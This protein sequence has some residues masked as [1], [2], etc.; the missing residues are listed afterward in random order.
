MEWVNFKRWVL[1]PLIVGVALIIVGAVAATHNRSV[2][3]ESVNKYQNETIK[4]IH[5][6]IKVISEDVKEILKKL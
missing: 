2:V 4:K 3:N 1:Y 6:D 5:T